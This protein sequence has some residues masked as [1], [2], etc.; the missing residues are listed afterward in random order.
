VPATLFL[1]VPITPVNPPNKFGVLARRA[2]VG[3]KEEGEARD[4][5]ASHDCK[6][7]D[8]SILSWRVHW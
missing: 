2:T 4:V 6:S 3:G 1:G 8:I 5:T 7:F